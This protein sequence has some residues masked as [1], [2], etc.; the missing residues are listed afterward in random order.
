MNFGD[1]DYNGDENSPSQPVNGADGPNNR[2]KVMPNTSV[3]SPLRPGGQR[4]PFTPRGGAGGGSLSRM[5][6]FSSTAGRQGPTT[7]GAS[8][9]GSPPSRGQFSAE[10]IGGSGAGN[11]SAAKPFNRLESLRTS[12][13][14]SSG[15]N[16]NGLT[17]GKGDSGDFMKSP[18]Q[19]LLSFDQFIKVCVYDVGDYLLMFGNINY[20][21]TRSCGDWRWSMLRRRCLGLLRDC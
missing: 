1:D 21:S 7:P 18:Q 14:S 11:G 5:G 4:T 16:L 6:S 8:R 12:I 20:S 9:G 3:V 13:L 15:S 2:S 19:V 17:P 10:D